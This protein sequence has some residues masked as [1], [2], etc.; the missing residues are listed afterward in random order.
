M[1]GAV[2]IITGAGVGDGVCTKIG[3]GAGALGV[4]A[5]DAVLVSLIPIEFMAFTV[6]VYEVPLVSPVNEQVVAT[7]VHSWPEFAVTL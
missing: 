3:A 6:K 2:G 5:I 1:T 4:I 7:A